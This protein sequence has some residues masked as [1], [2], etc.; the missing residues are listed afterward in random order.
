M[1]TGVMFAKEE[2]PVV[3]KE[4]ETSPDEVVKYRNWTVFD[5]ENFYQVP[6]L[7]NL[8]GERVHCFVNEEGEIV[9]L[10]PLN[11]M[12][13]QTQFD[14]DFFHDNDEEEQEE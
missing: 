12:V 3:S 2:T 7:T 1:K 10:F 4:E 11:F 9:A 8:C 14:K 5:G 13:Y 6:G